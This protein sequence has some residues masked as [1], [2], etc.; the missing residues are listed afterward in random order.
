MDLA[1]YLLRPVQRMAKYA[2]LLR[3]L[4]E[5]A[6][7]PAREQELGELRATEDVIRFQ[8]CLGNH[9]LAMDAMR[10][11]DVSARGPGG[12]ERA[13][14]EGFSLEPPTPTPAPGQQGAI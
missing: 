14:G 13:C 5:A 1:F 7:C 3:D 12:L 10:G 6:R 2:L 9:L 11:C 4:E 8:L